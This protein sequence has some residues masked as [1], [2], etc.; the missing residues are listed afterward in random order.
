MVKQ[1]EEIVE[2][3]TKILELVTFSI[4]SLEFNGKHIGRSI[5]IINYVGMN[6]PCNLKDIHANTQFPASTT[7]RRVD[8][9]VKIG[10]I[11]RVQSVGDRRGIRVTLTEEGQ[12]VYRLFRA[13]RIKS[14]RNFMKA[15]SEKEISIFS[16]VLRNLVENH[17]DIFVM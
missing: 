13:H 2:S 4:E 12:L 6:E 9:L 1:E 17:E 14:M 3:F 7:S 15:Y 11:D 5:F 10:L 8:D 16:K